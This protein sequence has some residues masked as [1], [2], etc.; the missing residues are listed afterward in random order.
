MERKNLL[1]N[2]LMAGKLNPIQAQEVKEKI[3]ETCKMSN[4]NVSDRMNWSNWINAKCQPNR[5]VQDQINQA[6]NSLGYESI[7]E[8]TTES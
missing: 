7:Y 6:L 1:R 5:F 4:S 3:F 8:I 2:F